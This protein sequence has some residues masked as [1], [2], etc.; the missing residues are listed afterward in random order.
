M[1]GNNKPAIINDKS[2]RMK[3]DTIH[4]AA[5]LGKNRIII[6]TYVEMNLTRKKC[7]ILVSFLIIPKALS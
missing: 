5:W 3:I 1:R 6:E 7:Y 2:N 4:T